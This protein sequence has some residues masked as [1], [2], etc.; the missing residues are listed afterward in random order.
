MRCATVTPVEPRAQA[1]VHEMAE[2]RRRFED[3]CRSLTAEE[4]RRQVPGTPWT[5]HDYI[6]HLCT[7]EALISAF[8]APFVG[9]T[10]IPRPEVA[11]PQP[12]DIDDWNAEMV[13]KRRGTLV[14]ELL[15]EGARNRGSYERV[16]GTMREAQ[17]DAMIPFGGDR[18][19]IDL[20]AT[21]VRLEGLLMAIAL[22]D[23]THMQDILRALPERAEEPVIKEW[24]AAADFSRV[25]PEIAERRA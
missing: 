24:L 23:P 17:L 8:F 2:H 5:A 1:I 21:T 19:V 12:F 22:H 9:R 6:A 15:A 4:L 14:D 10:D 25:P 13:A 16:L 7:V 3:F 18:K 20:P 11:P